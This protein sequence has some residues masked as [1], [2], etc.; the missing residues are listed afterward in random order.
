MCRVQIRSI[1]ALTGS[2]G[3]CGPVLDQ[4]PLGSLHHRRLL[5]VH[6]AGSTEPHKYDWLH[7][8]TLLWDCKNNT[9]NLIV[10]KAFYCPI[11]SSMLPPQSRSDDKQHYQIKLCMTAWREIGGNLRW[12]LILSPCVFVPF[13]GVEITEVIAHWRPV[14]FQQPP[15]PRWL[16][17]FTTWGI[18][19]PHFPLVLFL[20][21]FLRTWILVRGVCVCVCV[22]EIKLVLVHE[23][24]CT[25]TT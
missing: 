15:K 25:W 23:Y 4:D 14:Q 13:S 12:G 10:F 24:M 18:G 20:F 21:Y 7:T 6:R 1:S 9:A 2:T 16:T 8:A 3:H 22:C 19:A 11:K 5:H 17:V